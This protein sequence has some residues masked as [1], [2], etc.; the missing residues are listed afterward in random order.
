M[1]IDENTAKKVQE[2]QFLDQNL[3]GF[4]AQKQTVQLELNE[5]D[6]ALDEIKKADDSEIY[7]IIGGI[8]I[9][10]KKSDL[11]KDLEEKK[12]LL[13]LRISSIEKQEKL[14]EE[15]ASTLKEELNRELIKKG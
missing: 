15:K 12:K 1:N 11:T 4:I 14:L 7:K 10:A 3:Q 8:M 9:K 6:N 2:L 5:T 13:E